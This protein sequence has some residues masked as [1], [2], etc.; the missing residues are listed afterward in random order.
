[1][2]SVDWIHWL[3]ISTNFMRVSVITVL[4]VSDSIKYQALLAIQFRGF[5]RFL[6]AI[7]H[8]I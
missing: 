3:S 5:I 7:L 8:T 1:M 4:E 6:L 2:G